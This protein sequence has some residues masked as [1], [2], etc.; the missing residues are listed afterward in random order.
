M[1]YTVFLFFLNGKSQQYTILLVLFDE[2]DK[3]KLNIRNKIY[4]KPK[5]AAKRRE[6]QKKKTLMKTI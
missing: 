4:E 2:G 3:T 1:E 6:R 5:E